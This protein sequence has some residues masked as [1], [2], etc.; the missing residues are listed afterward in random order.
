VKTCKGCAAKSAAYT[1]TTG[2]SLPFGHIGLWHIAGHNTLTALC[3]LTDE[4]IR[5]WI[6]SQRK[7]LG[8]R[9]VHGRISYV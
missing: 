7:G 8:K 1:I 4:H 5:R 9:T 3:G 6:A 2:R